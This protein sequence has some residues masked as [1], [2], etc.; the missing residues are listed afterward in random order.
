MKKLIKLDDSELEDEREWRT[1]LHKLV[2]I[3][4]KLE[5]FIQEHHA[6]ETIECAVEWM[7][8]V[9]V[10]IKWKALPSRERSRLTH[11]GI[12]PMNGWYGE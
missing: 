9:D 6:P 2:L 5:S 10:Y 1:P 11:I 8:E 3:K 7:R 4:E 12:Y